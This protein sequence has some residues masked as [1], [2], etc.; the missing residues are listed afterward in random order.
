MVEPS[1]KVSDLAEPLILKLLLNLIFN[2]FYGFK[3]SLNFPRGKRI[4]IRRI[5]ITFKQNVSKMDLQ[6]LV[7]EDDFFVLW[8]IGF[9]FLCELFIFL[10]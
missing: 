6:F 2:L 4:Q 9:E 7:S 10:D 8:L 5:I 3:V 1:L